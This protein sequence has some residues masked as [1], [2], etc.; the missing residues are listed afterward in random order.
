MRPLK[1]ALV[2]TLVLSG[3]ASR[4]VPE[5][6]ECSSRLPVVLSKINV[7]ELMGKMVQEFCPSGSGPSNPMISDRDVVV[8]SDFVDITNFSTGHAGVYLGE[9]ARG[10]LSEVCRHRV[11]QVDLGKVVK[12]NADGLVVLT[13]DSSRVANAEFVS[14]WAYVGTY[15]ELPGRI[16]LTLRELDLESGSTTRILAREVNHGCK[17]VYGEYKFNYSLN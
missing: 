11:R 2:F 16:L 17:L 9:V 3:C 8:V 7:T 1:L 10:S 14:K 12:L 4:Y 13:R 6:I 15:S 5:P